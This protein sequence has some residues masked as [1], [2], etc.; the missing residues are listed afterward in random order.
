MRSFLGL[1]RY[2][3]SFVV[4]FAGIAY[5]LFQTL[6]KDQP[7]KFQTT[8]EIR[9]AVD[10]LKQV[11]CSSPILQFPNFN[12]TFILETDAS[13]TRIAAILMQYYDGHKAIIAAASRVLTAAEKNYSTVEKEAKAV[14][15]AIQHFRPYLFGTNFIV[16]TDHE[17]LKY[18]DEFKNLN[19]RMVRWLLTLQEYNFQ[20]VY[21]SGNKIWQLMHLHA[22]L[23]QMTTFQN[24][25]NHS[26]SSWMMNPIHP[27]TLLTQIKLQKI[28]LKSNKMTLF[29]KL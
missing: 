14:V 13:G 23:Q 28:S 25:Q 6:Q 1:A 26:Q 19:S 16:I 15:W 12:Q 9:G 2:Y 3:R 27:V 11:L 21:R 29:A 5:P 24:T 18:L 17:C 8:E 7:E 20:V 4:D 10:K 22:S